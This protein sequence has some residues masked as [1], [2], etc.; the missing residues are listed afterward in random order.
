MYPKY[1]NLVPRDV[2]MREI[3]MMWTK[4]NMGINGQNKVYLDL[5]H[6][7]PAELE[8]KLGGIIDMYEKYVGVD[9]KR[10]PIDIFPAV[11]YSMGGLWCDFNQM[12]NI[13]GLFAGG[14]AEYQYHGANRLGANSLMSC[15]F[16][17]MVLGPQVSLYLKNLPSTAEDADASLFERALKIEQDDL[18]KISGMGGKENAHKLWTELG[19]IM[20]RNVTIV[21]Y[22]KNLEE[23]YDKLSE[24]QERWNDLD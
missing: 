3:F 18:T 10:E 9:P 17:G 2:A 11:H 16:A 24:F 21:R 20:T 13:P 7:D 6:K 4:M 8:R 12:T 15:L 5:S 19:E 14:E 22:N 1:G 23:T